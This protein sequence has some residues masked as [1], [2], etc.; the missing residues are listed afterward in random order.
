MVL[1][2]VS[3]FRAQAEGSASN[4]PDSHAAPV[5]PTIFAVVNIVDAIASVIL[6][7]IWVDC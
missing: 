6:G 2:G 5:R 3:G 1:L 4:V 7:M